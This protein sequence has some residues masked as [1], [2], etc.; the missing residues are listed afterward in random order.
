[1]K[2]EFEQRRYAVAKECPCGKS[3]KDG[4][5]ATFKGE[6]KYG[7]CHSCGDVFFPPE[8]NQ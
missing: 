5:F 3:N 7:K 4:K 8:D 6:E 2:T 1:M